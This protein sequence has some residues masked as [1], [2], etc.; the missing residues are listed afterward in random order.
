MKKEKNGMF[1]KIF[2]GKKSG[3]C[4]VKIEEMPDEKETSAAPNPCCA[5]TAPSSCCTPA[6]S[7]CCS[8]TESKGKEV[9]AKN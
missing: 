4:D 8:P 1:S 5:P 2:G 3:C 7:D 9:G 6:A